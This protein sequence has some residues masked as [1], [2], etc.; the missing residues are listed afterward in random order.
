MQVRASILWGA[1]YATVLI[2]LGATVVWTVPRLDAQRDT[3]PPAEEDLVYLPEARFLRPISLGYNNALAALLW[4]RTIGYF[5]LHYRSDRLYPW[6]AHMCEIVTDL[7]PR[8]EYVYRFG[9][10]LLPWEANQVDAGIKLLKKGMH[11]IP[12]SWMIPFWLGF[13]EYFFKHDYEQALAAVQE[14][15][16]RPGV[17][18]MVTRF[19]SV[20]AARQHG[21]E[22]TMQLL[23]QMEKETDRDDVR[24]VIRE[25]MRKAQAAVDIER[26][27]RTVELYQA[28]FGSPPTSLQ[29]LVHTH[30]LTHIPDDPLGG[31][32]ELDPGTNTV[33]SST[34]QRPLEYHGHG[35]GDAEREGAMD[36]STR[37]DR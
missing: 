22:L 26:L 3:Q 37:G 33:R 12:D 17:D 28:R 2:V 35:P 36:P 9:G 7:D 14:A 29:D 20:L 31:V 4:F 30:I 1:S 18:P 15:I 21:P 5:G 11:A 32:Y 34:G 24:S 27:N 10:V 8:A 19:A 16:R 6:L 23:A 13:N 25:Q